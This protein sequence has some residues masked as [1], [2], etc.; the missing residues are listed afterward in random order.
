M[1]VDPRPSCGI[2]E[3]DQ[4]GGFIE[5]IHPYH[6]N[7]QCDWEINTECQKIQWTFETI[8]LEDDSDCFFD[9]V[10]VFD[11]DRDEQGSEDYNYDD[12]YYQYYDQFWHYE[13]S[14]HFF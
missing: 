13:S 1:P 5:S 2:S 14:S 11:H 3:S 8:E 10:I 12:Y 4:S 9:K 6:N 7:S